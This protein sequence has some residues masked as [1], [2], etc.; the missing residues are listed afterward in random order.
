MSLK[1]PNEIERYVASLLQVY[2]HKNQALL[3]QLLVNA[4]V[5]VEEHSYDKTPEGDVY[6]FLLHLRVPEAIFSEIIV[7]LSNIIK[8]L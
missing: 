5:D 2:K 6:G 7:L 1:L 4:E 3:Q 8:V